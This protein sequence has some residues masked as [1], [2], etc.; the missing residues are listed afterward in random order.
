MFFR[1]LKKGLFQI[2]AIVL[3]GIFHLMV[4]I[5]FGVSYFP[6]SWRSSRTALAGTWMHIDF[7]MTNGTDYLY[8]SSISSTTTSSSVVA[9]TV[10]IF[11]LPGKE[12]LGIRMFLFATVIAGQ[13]AFTLVSGFDNP[14]GLQMVENVPFCHELS[15]IAIFSIKDTVQMHYQRCLLCLVYLQ[16]LLGSC[17]TYWVDSSKGALYTTSPSTYLLDVLVVLVYSLQK[18]VSKLQWIPYLQYPRSSKSSIY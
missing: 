11:P 1:S 15:H 13:V 18:L 7:L 12:A 2:P 14:I 16:L 17:F 8:N 4:G 9:G 3:I 6:V 5:P 10:G